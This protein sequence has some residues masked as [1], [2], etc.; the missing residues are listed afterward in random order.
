MANIV[1]PP[2][3]IEYV[4]SLSKQWPR[5]RLLVDFANRDNKILDYHGDAEVDL[6]M[7]TVDVNVIDFGLGSIK[8]HHFGDINELTSHLDNKPPSLQLRV[9]MVENLSAIVIE[10]LGGKYSLDPRFFENHLRGIE[11]FF[12]DR[13]TGDK[14]ARLES[15]SSEVLNREFFT[16]TYTR[17]YLFK[18]WSSTYTS[19][20]KQNVPRLANVARNLFMREKA[21]LYWST[22]CD[23]GYSFGKCSIGIYMPSSMFLRLISSK[24]V[25][26]SDP[27]LYEAEPEGMYLRQNDQLPKYSQGITEVTGLPQSKQI[28]TRSAL[29]AT[30]FR[31]GNQMHENVK[32]TLV[33][34]IL[35][36]ALDFH[37]ATLD[38]LY[39]FLFGMDSMHSQRPASLYQSTVEALNNSGGTIALQEYVWMSLTDIKQI[40]INFLRSNEDRRALEMELQ[41]LDTIYSSVQRR[42]NRILQY[43]QQ[44]RQMHEARLNRI[45][46][47]C[48]LISTIA[49]IL[50]IQDTRRFITFGVFIL[51]IF[52]FAT[53]FGIIGISLEDSLKAINRISDS[54]KY[55]LARL[56]KIRKKNIDADADDRFGRALERDVTLPRKV[57]AMKA[58]YDERTIKD[59]IDRTERRRSGF[60]RHES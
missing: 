34:S 25:V 22:E 11:L 43:L 26:L 52:L 44:E 16:V 1:H 24:V 3:Y 21:S 49:A 51:P 30:L 33:K 13:W 40:F 32:D 15:S 58:S 27:L 6:R 38:E 35:S 55:L 4:R 47:L 20:L 17:P 56:I 45:V 2:S 19:R 5:L 37:T 48:I 29:T 31:S 18:G 60:I 7:N 36:L 28:S 42:T 57:V 12:T 10:L 50:G 53:L 14:T 8:T 59:F 23:D 46:F 39:T 41:S 9:F 54:S